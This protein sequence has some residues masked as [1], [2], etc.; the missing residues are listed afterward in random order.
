MAG[1]AFSKN[2]GTGTDNIGAG[3]GVVCWVIFVPHAMVAWCQRCAPLLHGSSHQTLFV[4][5]CICYY[6]PRIAGY[7][8]PALVVQHF[9]VSWTWALLSGA[10]STSA[11][12][13]AY[14]CQSVLCHAHTAIQ[15]TPC[16]QQDEYV[17][18]NTQLGLCSPSSHECIEPAQ[19]AHNMLQRT[20][21]R[22]PRMSTCST[23]PTAGCAPRASTRSRLRTRR[24]STS[25]RW[26]FDRI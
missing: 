10:A 5:T 24:S 1:V 20:H 23:A 25:S 13:A 16:A 12:P 2:V 3:C 6:Y 18:H 11:P 26:A 7:I 21:R 9:L 8:I 22:T 19:I 15:P 14:K 4:V 17:Q